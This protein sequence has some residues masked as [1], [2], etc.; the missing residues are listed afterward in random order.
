MGACLL[1]TPVGP[2]TAWKR[3]ELASAL[4]PLWW[5]ALLAVG[6][7]LLKRRDA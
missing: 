2:L 6:A 1:L 4:K 5:A 3:A 7:Y